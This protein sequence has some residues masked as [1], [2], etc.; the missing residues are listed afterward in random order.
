[1]TDSPASPSPA[2][3]PVQHHRNPSQTMSASEG[4]EALPLGE[5]KLPEARLNRNTAPA[6]AR[7]TAKLKEAIEIMAYEGLGIPMTAQRVGMNVEA[8]KQALR[9]KHVRQSLNQLI[10]DIRAGS[11]Q[12]A[13]LRVNHLS[14]VAASETVKLEANKWVAG[15]GD[16]APIRRVEGRHSHHVSFSGFDMD[17]SPVDITPDDDA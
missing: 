10:T 13:F 15:V 7:L 3:D 14:Q 5:A 1:M 11:A 16:I 12:A 2:R 6:R 8:L 4:G 17:L 9:K